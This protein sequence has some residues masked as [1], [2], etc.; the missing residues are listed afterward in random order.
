[1]GIE[2]YVIGQEEHKDGN[3]HLHAVV[4]MKKKCNIVS[5]RALDI[6]IDGV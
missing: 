6:E 4:S 1:M 2:K 3:L 5:P